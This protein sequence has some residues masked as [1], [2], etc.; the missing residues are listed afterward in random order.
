MKNKRAT[1]IAVALVVIVGL[2][3][4]MIPRQD[5]CTDTVRGY[6]EQ[7]SSSLNVIRTG[8]ESLAGALG[9][10][11]SVEVPQ[12]E[13]L[14]AANFSA[15]RACEVQCRLLTRC[16]RFVFFTSPSSA[17]PQEYKD[18]KE[19]QQRAEQLLERLS[20]IGS[21]VNKAQ[22]QVPA[23]REAR[24]EVREIEVT[25]GATGNQ[26]ALA[27]ARQRRLEGEMAAQVSRISTELS[28][29]RQ[30]K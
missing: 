8:Y 17:C 1:Y 11:S 16:L 30:K 19:T 26:L 7:A 29:L 6:K 10:G 14:D 3:L 27:Q 21:E 24:A 20:M 13:D 5:I 12:I 15:L 2:L 9:R 28:K 25:S 4:V 23:I 18:L 22:A